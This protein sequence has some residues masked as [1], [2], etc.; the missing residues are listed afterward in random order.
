MRNLI[1][2]ATAACLAATAL[3]STVMPPEAGTSV[4]GYQDDFATLDATLWSGV[5]VDAAVNTP[6]VLT[7]NGAGG[8][9]HLYLSGLA[10][11]GTVQE[12]LALVRPVDPWAP[13]GNDGLRGGVA[14]NGGGSQAYNLLLREKEDENARMLDDGL[15]WGP[16]TSTPFATGEW[17][18]LRF[19]NTGSQLQGKAWF[20]AD[21]EP[22]DWTTWDRSGRTGL[23][24]L[25]AASSDSVQST[26]EVDYFLLKADG[27]PTITVVPEPATVALLALG[28]LLLRRR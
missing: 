1:G 11:D 10:Y 25:T 4:A 12:V 8:D 17:Y 28:G 9:A 6:G 24:G 21:S 16:S 3:A 19:R 23:A 2:I 14:L 5:N 13:S 26:L 15:A 20:A 27:L 18:W 7:L 22:A